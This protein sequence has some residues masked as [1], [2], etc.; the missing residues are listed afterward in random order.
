M[1]SI[2]YRS[3]AAQSI[4]DYLSGAQAE[5]G[6]GREDYYNRA[7]C[8]GE[9]HGSGAEALGLT[10]PVSV[11]AFQRL[12]DGYNPTTGAALVQNAGGDKRRP[13]WDLTFSPDKSVSVAWALADEP[14]RSQM[15]AA[16]DAAVREALAWAE[17]QSVFVA[18]RGK[19]GVEH[20]SAKPILALYEHHTS[21][22]QDPQLHTHS[23]LFNLAGRA[24]GTYGAIETSELYR[25]KTSLGAAY[26]VSLAEKL[27]ALGIETE[28]G[29]TRGTA[30][31]SGVSADVCA[32]F[33]RRRSQVVA[34]LEAA[35]AA[36]AKA[37]EAAALG[38]RAAKEHVDEAILMSDWRHRA[39]GHGYTAETIAQLQ[40][41][42]RAREPQEIDTAAIIAALTQQNSTFERRDMIR[43]VAIEVLAAGG[44]LNRVDQVV[45]QI[46]HHKEIMHLRE[47]RMTTREMY[48]IESE[49]MDRMTRMS[50]DGRHALSKSAIAAAVVEVNAKSTHK[51]SVQQQAA[52]EHALSAG[53]LKV[54]VGGAGSGKTTTAMNTTATALRAAG[55]QLIGTA[56]AGKAASGLQQDAG[57][58]S[59]TVALLLKQIEGGS[60]KLTEKTAVVLDEAGM[61]DSRQFAKL[62]AHVEKAG[63]KLICVG[64]HRQLQ[65]IEAGGLFNRAVR[66]L[67]SAWMVEN[68]R[69][70]N[71]LHRDA[72]QDV[73]RDD[74]HAAIEKYRAEG[75]VHT[76]RSRVDLIADMVARWK[77]DRDPSRPAE[78]LM[79]AATRADVYEL[80]Q[81]ARTLLRD[82]LSPVSIRVQTAFGEREFAAG[83]RI[84]IK[85]NDRQIGERIDDK[86]VT[87]G[88][89]NGE[90][91]TVIRADHDALGRP[92]LIVRLDN[93]TT[94]RID[95]AV[96]QSYD[97]GYAVTCHAAQGVTVDK[98]HVLFHE[99]MVDREWMHVSLTRHRESAHI[100]AHEFALEDIE[101]AASR[102]RAK[103]TSLDYV[104]SHENADKN[105]ES[106]HVAASQKQPQ[107]EKQQ[108]QRQEPQQRRT[109]VREY[110]I[111]L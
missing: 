103:M 81:T 107:Q 28:P 25:F 35:G 27:R 22:E 92:R 86:G 80:N 57:I 59:R 79:I 51:M 33:S 62:V 101:R 70:R 106:K 9:W 104:E 84:I 10:G 94:A 89:K 73:L 88:V 32:E 40:Q 38:T 97:H 110:E 31:I 4:I 74:A 5:P 23:F 34:A 109:R 90:L 1:L 99:S 52:A 48:K 16:H 43:A 69:Q 87:R 53:S 26:Q 56:L 58:D 14:L 7:E 15:Q 21:R 93:G 44:G 75:A 108:E 3:G 71:Q 2:S 66:D 98:T 42:G 46:E 37:A 20:E 68:W 49:A 50:A 12:C 102:S 77:T 67:D 64:D 17:E 13:G 8:V 55:Y 105:R 85:K 83:D 95:P 24:D 54:I 78:C 6:A 41:P 36:S 82:T 91:G 29:K 30:R 65:P 111:E 11:D 72:V 100:Y 61:L 76:S 60:V 63:A 18:R 39:A 19:A 96:Y 45:Q 47:Y